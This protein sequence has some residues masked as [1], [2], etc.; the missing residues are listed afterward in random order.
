MK[1]VLRDTHGWYP[2]AILTLGGESDERS[3]VHYALSREHA[4]LLAARLYPDREILTI[5]WL[6]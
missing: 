1:H 2:F 6:H 4:F 5:T 3:E